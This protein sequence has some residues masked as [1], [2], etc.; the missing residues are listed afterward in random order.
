[1][2]QGAPARVLRHT[3][4]ARLLHGAAV[5]AVALLLPTG[6]ALGEMLPPGW[7]ARLGGHAAASVGHDLLGLGFVGLAALVLVVG[8]RGAGMLLR[9]L[10]QVRRADVVWLG[11]FLRDG[12]GRRPPRAWHAARLDPLQRWVI[13]VVLAALAALAVSGVVLYFAP[14]H[15]R[16]VFVV[17]V[18]AHALAGCVLMLALLVHAIAG[19][20]VLPTHRGVARSMFGDGTV[21]LA[22][23]RR[24]WPGWTTSRVARHPPDTER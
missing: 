7:V 2:T 21:P 19:L 10:G 14:A 12:A 18:R 17:A 1:M 22:T 9:E 4:A 11:A 8:H 15:W 13:A 3:L 20:G 23:A 24:L 5:L 6:L 16:W